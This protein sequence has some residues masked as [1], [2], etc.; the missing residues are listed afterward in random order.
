[1]KLYVRNAFTLIELL[2]V[3]AIIAILIALLVPA[4]Q[5][6]RAA[7]ANTQCKNNLKQIALASHNYHAAFKQFPA[8]ADVQGVGEMVYLL[9]YIDQ[10]P[11]FAA[12]SFRP[13][14]YAMYY[15]DPVNRPA[16][17]GVATPPRPP[18][19][20]G[21]EP[22]IAVFHCPAAPVGTTTALLGVWYS[23]SGV[24]FPAAVPAAGHSFSSCPGCNVMGRSNYLGVGGYLGV[25]GSGIAQGIYTW[26]SAI[27]I[28]QISDGTSNTIAFAEYAGGNIVWGGQGG[29][30]DGMAAASWSAG[31]NYTG[32]GG[33]GPQGSQTASGW[34]FFGADHIGY[35][36]NCAFADGT[37]RGISPSISFNTWIYMSGINDGVNVSFDP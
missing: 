28:V 13:S 30:P 9:P 16:S 6:V 27:K 21:V 33:P 26:K 19:V 18:A 10:Q 1:M 14:S 5:K 12:Y 22:D 25:S 3:I 35:V 11:I 15:Q 29:I 36:C 2:V 34:A 24:D 8:G 31:F 4:V 23:T 37:V 7:A 20:Y 17:T 32:F